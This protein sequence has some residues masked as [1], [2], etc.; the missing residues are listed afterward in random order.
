MATTYT[1][2]ECEGWEKRSKFVFCLQ[3]HF[4][5]LDTVK[6]KS[7]FVGLCTERVMQAGKWNGATM[8]PPRSEINIQQ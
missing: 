8:L 1:S 4:Y 6:V 3:K 2:K 5:F 7:E